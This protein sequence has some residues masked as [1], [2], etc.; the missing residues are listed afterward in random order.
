M[1]LFPA[2]V[3]WQPLHLI[4]YDA[5]HVLDHFA[6]RPFSMMKLN[7]KLTQTLLCVRNVQLV[8]FDYFRSPPHAAFEQESFWQTE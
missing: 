1:Y 5:D 7:T 8:A 6:A 3:A 4:L 2:G